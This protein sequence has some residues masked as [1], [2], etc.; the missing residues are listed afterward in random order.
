VVR[1]GLKRQTILIL[2]PQSWGTMFLSKHHYA[3]ELARRGN[4][5]FFLNPP[6]QEKERGKSFI[7]IKPLEGHE[8][9][10][11]IEHRLFFP[12]W[13]KFK[14][15]GVFHWL[16]Q[17]HIKRIVARIDQ[18]LQLVWS[19]DLGNLYPLRYFRV[20]VYKVFHPVDEPLNKA[21]IDAAEGADILFSVTHEILE[22][23]NHCEAPKYFINH[24]VSEEFLEVGEGHTNSQETLHV[25]W[26]GNLLRPEIDR[27]ILL[28]IIHENPRVTF[29]FWGSHSLKQTNIGGAIDQETEKFI[30]R[31]HQEQNVKLHGAVSSGTLATAIR[32]MDAFLICYDIEKDQS[33]GTNYH[34][35]MEY[36]STGKITISNN[37]TTYRDRP[38]LIQMISDRKS[39]DSLPELFR[40][41]VDNLKEYN[42]SEL[43]R[44]RRRFAADNSYKNQTDRIEKIVAEHRLME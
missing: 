4:S 42:T 33:K 44:L 7:E 1:T 23:Y 27:E 21:A 31:L 13:L 12:Y 39:N 16:I 25:G 15:Q 38:E 43:I 9:L 8:N 2:S 28:R 36:I 17:F 24:G 5:V 40:R 29:D 19:F 30:T 37:V 3:L 26:S 18:P 10:F 32:D 41:V 11:L 20:P 34:K 6:Q 35:I 22:K 14:A